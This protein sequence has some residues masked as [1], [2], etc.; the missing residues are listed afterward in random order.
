M[1]RR[2][3]TRTPKPST[4]KRTQSDSQ[5]STQRPKKPKAHLSTI[6]ATLELLSSSDEEEQ[7]LIDLAKSGAKETKEEKEQEEN[8]EDNDAKEEEESTPF[9]FQTTWKALCSKEFLPS[10]RSIYYIKD[11]LIMD[12][13]EQWKQKVLYNLQPRS[14]QVVSLLAV[15]LYKKCQQANK[16]F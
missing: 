7:L 16:F 4:K 3:S 9:K 11:M 2:T 1:P 14:F 12:D 13:I 10:I 8:I 6:S 15:A 5:P